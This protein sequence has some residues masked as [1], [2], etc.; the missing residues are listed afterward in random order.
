MKNFQKK[1]VIIPLIL[2]IIGIASSGRVSF[3]FSG[4][5][6]VSDGN[7]KTRVTRENFA[8]F[9]DSLIIPEE[10]EKIKLDTYLFDSFDIITGD[11]KYEG[12]FS[13]N[14]DKFYP[15]VLKALRRKKAKEESEKI[16]DNTDFV[17]VYNVNFS[18]RQQ[19]SLVM[20][21]GTNSGNF[22]YSSSGKNIQSAE[23]DFKK[24]IE[25]IK[26]YMSQRNFTRALRSLD[27]ARQQSEGNNP[28][29][30]IAAQLY[31]KI[32]RQDKAGEIYKELAEAEPEKLEYVYGY[33]VCLY[34]NNETDKAEKL[35]LK[36]SGINPDFMYSYYNLG[37]LY[38]KK[39][40]Y[41]KAV[42]Y[43]NKALEISPSNPDIYFNIA[44]ALEQAHHKTLAK[45]YYKRCIEL[46]PADKQAEKAYE[47]LDY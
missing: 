42:D 4:Y 28:Q 6:S 8:E 47:R 19:N 11:Y 41:Y 1:S 12:L 45:K 13:V 36:V 21:F 30:Y 7:F 24:S 14:N 2:C 16:V 15:D 18:G 17:P 26:L 23:F 10:K 33:A 27:F 34:K 38:Y 44:V 37:N 40:D 35:F 29:L 9:C 20:N 43:F 22:M 46:N 32:N 25:N 5:N 31:E 39:G 3:A